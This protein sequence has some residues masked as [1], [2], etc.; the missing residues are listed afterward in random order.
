MG[1]YEFSE[2]PALDRLQTRRL[3][4]LA[5]GQAAYTLLLNEDG[6]VFNDATVW[7]MGSDRWWLFTGRRSDFARFRD[8]ARDRSG[9]YAIFAL[10]G[11]LSGRVLSRLVGEEGVRRLK[12]FRFIET[13]GMLV[14][15][16]G[17][18]GELGY[19]LLVPAAEEQALRASLLDAGRAAGLCECTFEA[20]DSLRIESGYV[21]FDREID[22]RT[23]PRE[24]GLERLV[25]RPRA[26]AF[27]RKLVGFEILEGKA[28]KDSRWLL[29]RVNVSHPP[30]A[31]ASDWASPLPTPISDI[32]C[33]CRTDVWLTSRS[34]RSTTVT[35][36]G[37]AVRRSEVFA[38][39]L[40]AFAPAALAQAPPEP[41]PM[42]ED[43]PSRRSP[44]ERVE[45]RGTQDSDLRRN[46]IAG[47]IVIGREEIERFGDTTVGEVLRRLPSVTLGGRPGRGGEIRLRGM[48]SGFTQIL[49][50]GERMPAGLALETLTPDQIERIELFRAPTAEHGARAIAGTINIVLREPLQRRLNDLRLTAGSRTGAGNRTSAGRATTGSERKGRTTCP[51]RRRAIRGSM[52]SRLARA[53]SMRLREQRCA[54]RRRRAPRS[55]GASASS[56]PRGCTGAMARERRLR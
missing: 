41:A 30:S 48:G 11:P 49:V 55:T 15:R 23:N 8:H 10:Q 4:D 45:I 40:A 37:R 24:L 1:L 36:S 25:N 6:S 21:L 33:V 35:G 29:S 5:P 54:T 26:F 32:G 16:L 13:K 39:A 34:C 12:Y 27:S 52:T 28:H 31:C 47:K 50:D 3:A 7:S 20:A 42:Q 56:C 19:E 44:V 2:T 38:V 43:T 53:K 22:G 46:A 9:E 18:S 14:A 51:F 17:Y